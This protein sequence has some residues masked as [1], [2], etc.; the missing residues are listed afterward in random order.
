MRVEYS[1]PLAQLEVPTFSV[2]TTEG[3]R[4][5][6][7][8]ATLILNVLSQRER[9]DVIFHSPNREDLKKKVGDFH[10]ILSS[11]PG[12]VELSFEEGESGAMGSFYYLW[13]SIRAVGARG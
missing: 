5:L 12:G 13:I 8:L 11:A 4:K 6:F 10:K 2:E 1:F 3:P 9:A 7:T